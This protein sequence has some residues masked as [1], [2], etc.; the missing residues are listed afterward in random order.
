M[1]RLPHELIRQI[2]LEFFLHETDW[3]TMEEILVLTMVSKKWQNAILSEPHLWNYIVLDNG[4]ENSDLVALQVRLSIPLPLTVRVHLPFERCDTVRPGLFETRQRIQEIIFDFEYLPGDNGDNRKATDLW[5][6]LDTLGPLPS[7]R[8]LR[9]TWMDYWSRLDIKK[10]LDQYPSLEQVTNIPLTS[11]DLHLAGGRLKI[12]TLL[13]CEA[14]KTILPILETQINLNTVA[15]YARDP[16]PRQE[17]EVKGSEKESISMHPLGWTE[18]I[19]KKR[20]SQLPFSLLRRLSFLTRLELSIDFDSFNEMAAVLHELQHLDELSISMFR[21]VNGSIWKPCELSPNLNVRSL[22]IF[23]HCHPIRVYNRPEND[24]TEAI[25]DMHNATEAVVTTLLRILPNVMTLSLTFDSRRSDFPLF[26]LENLFTGDDLTLYLVHKGIQESNSRL[27]PS[28]VRTL[29]LS[30]DRDVACTFSSKSVKSL[31]IQGPFLSEEYESK[32]S[33]VELNLEDWEA[34]E[35]IRV[36]SGLV[37]WSKSSLQFLRT[38]SIGMATGKTHRDSIITSFVKD[39]AC[40]PDAYPSLEEIDMPECPELDILIIMLERRNLR[41]GPGVKII[42]RI[43]FRSPC[44]FRI[45]LIISTLLAGKWV[46]RPSNRD[47]SLAG[48]AEVLLDLNL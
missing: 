41:H 14:L 47:L 20:S 11:Q 2:L 1:D 21:R 37:A 15:F 6:F 17:V 12:E 26:S 23:T 3:G 44:S 36:Y 42:R 40:R 7:L 46:Q 38:V 30:S 19:Y 5:T 22:G 48:N 18:F 29:T 35:D 13:T 45:R 9:D 16:Q 8:Y 39:L 32:P 28:S 24:I 25:N 43:S 27:I 34:V 33:D 4:N 10:L 31:T